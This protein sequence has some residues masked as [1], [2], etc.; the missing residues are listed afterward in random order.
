M[1]LLIKIF[2]KASLKKNLFLSDEEGV[3]IRRA[4][5][6]E[7]SKVIRWVLE[8]FHEGWADECAAAFGHQPIDCF[9]A[10]HHL[11]ICG[12]CCLNTTFRNFIGPI[13]VCK[14][15]R[16]KGIGKKLVL[17]ALC[18]LY[19]EGYAYAVVGDAGQPNFFKA[20]VAAIEIPG[21]ATGAYPERIQSQ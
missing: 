21:S 5:A 12:F 3:T 20:A 8:T 6:Y 17:S 18:Q 1:D 7:R 13:G 2:D 4:M 11:K 15:E 16:R 9:I 14:I 10:I 19:N